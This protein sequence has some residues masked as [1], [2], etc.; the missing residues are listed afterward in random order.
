[1]LTQLQLSG[2]LRN[3]AGIAFGRFTDVPD[4]SDFEQRPLDDLLRGV[5]RRCAVPCLANIPLGHIPDQWTL[6]L[7]AVAELDADARTLSIIPNA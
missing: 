7:G 5:A 1:M 3:L 6:P 2:A 4:D